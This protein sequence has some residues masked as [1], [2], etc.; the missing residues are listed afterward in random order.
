[1]R[2]RLICFASFLYDL[3]TFVALSVIPMRAVGM[4]ASSTTLALLQTSSTVVYV[5][6]SLVVGRLADR[7][8]KAVL[9]RIGCAGGIAAC[10]LIGGVDTMPGLFVSAA[11]LGLGS[12]IFWPAVQGAIG[13]ETPP[14]RMEDALAFFNFM[15][16]LG[17]TL[18]YAAAGWLVQQHGHAYAMWVAA[19]VA[20]PIVLFYPWGEGARPAA[21]HAAASPDRGRF[22]TIGYAANFA[23]FGLGTI[24]QNQF[25]KF[26][27]GTQQE[28]MLGRKT[29]FGLFLG[30][31]YA[32]QT[33][34]FLVLRNGSWWTYRR[35]PL[36]ASQLVV[37]GAAA[38]I[39]FAGSDVAWLGL[40][41]VIGAGIG[42]SYASSIYYSLHGPAD[43][44]KYA[45]LH[46]AVLGTG[47]FLIPLAGG[48]LAD[49]TGDLRMPYVL[50]A[51]AV[52]VSI[53]VQEG[54]YRTR[55]SS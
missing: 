16:S 18:G 26:L 8:P 3:P 17:K 21:V 25:Y 29:F 27:E 20:A 5:V 2:L 23:A 44:G 22:R 46:E 32:V 52:L 24:F 15:W 39:P 53:A 35:V 48:K 9:A 51:G 36:Y 4:N 33:A 34:S 11:L 50:A 37:A 12:S 13:S 45:G 55:S 43:H 7:W 54:V 10:F 42:F 1:V 30:V 6:T 38:A 19:G 41:A 47:S 28:V 49:L 40:A 31:I 14:D